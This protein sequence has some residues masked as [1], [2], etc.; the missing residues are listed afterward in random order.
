MPDRHAFALWSPPGRP[1]VKGVTGVIDLAVPQ[2]IDA[3]DQLHAQISVSSIECRIV[4]VDTLTDL[5]QA[6]PP[7]VGHRSLHAWADLIADPQR[8]VSLP[9]AAHAVPDAVGH[10]MTSEHYARATLAET[11]ALKGTLATLVTA[12][13]RDYQVRGVGFLAE[14]VRATGGAV[15]SDEMGLGKTLQAIAFL[16]NIAAES[17]NPALVIC[18]TSLVTN[19][20]RELEHFAPTLRA[21]AYRGGDLAQLDDV[22]VVVTGYPTLRGHQSSL[23]AATWSTLVFDEAQFLKNHRTQV[24][25]AARGLNATARIALTGTP[26]ENHLDEL[27]SILNLVAKPQYGNRTL[28]RRRYTLPIAQG[29]TDAM[30]RMRANI[31]PIVLGRTK[32]QVATTLPAKLHTDITCDLSDEQAAKYDA[33]LNAAV[34]AGFGEGTTRHG[35]ILATLTRLKQVCNHPDLATPDPEWR[36][37]D[38]AGRSGKLDAL[39]DVIETNL[40]TDSPTIIFTQYRRTG[41]L[42]RAHLTEVFGISVPY[43]HGGLGGAARDVIV[44]DYQAGRGSGI[45]LASVKA[46]GTGLT[47]T[48]A[49]DVVHFDRWWNPA[50]EAQASDRVHRIGQTRTVTVTTLTTAG[51]IEE[52]IAAMH[53]RKSALTLDSDSSALAE[54][55]ALSD[56]GLIEM[57]RRTRDEEVC[58]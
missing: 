19:W 32:A 45:L 25:K 52:H 10:T 24:S 5:A 38:L 55:T 6:H 18:P 27:W 7:S 20:L 29:S 57:L 31:A 49:A 14:A 36:T 8:D 11:L 3:G 34:E 42:L 58:E 56:E 28:F 39:T 44:D 1:T 41:E 23:T 12:N 21:A 16:A 46:A 22:D 33:L 26:V 17:D 53:R 43:L 40:E 51:T 9:P 37:T 13:L 4:D 35:R 2:L 54:L 15:L 50:V 47:L 48:R 30:R